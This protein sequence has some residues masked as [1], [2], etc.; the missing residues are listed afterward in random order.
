MEYVRFWNGRAHAAYDQYGDNLLWED[1]NGN[2]VYTGQNKAE[3]MKRYNQN[4][5]GWL[6]FPFVLPLCCL[7]GSI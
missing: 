4:P 3:Y 6:L 1:L 7:V 2:P 5:M